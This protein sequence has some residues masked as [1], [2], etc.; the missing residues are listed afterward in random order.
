MGANSV[1]PD[2]NRS[3]DAGID[4]VDHQFT[5]AFECDQASPDGSPVVA[6]TMHRRF[7]EIR[8]TQSRKSVQWFCDNDMRKNKDLKRKERI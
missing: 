3:Y 6:A 7:R 8:L 1:F 5:H 4:K 2:G